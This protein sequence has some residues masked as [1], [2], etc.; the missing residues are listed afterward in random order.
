MTVAR[1]SSASRLDVSLDRL[2]RRRVLQAAGLAVALASM[3]GRP[4]S[5]EASQPR[6]ELAAALAALPA[7]AGRLAGLPHRG[8]SNG[9]SSGSDSFAYTRI[10]RDV[11]NDFHARPSPPT[12]AAMA[13]VDLSAGKT[14]AAVRLLEM[15]VAGSPSGA[16]RAGY[17][18]D[19]AVAHLA[20]AAALGE[21]HEIV[22]ALDLASE[23]LDADPALHAA[24]FNRAL[25]LE[26]LQLVAQARRVWHSCARGEPDAEWQAEIDR[27]LSALTS[28]QPVGETTTAE[29][30]EQV[31]PRWGE[32]FLAGRELEAS[33]AA[34]Q[35][36]RIGE[37]LAHGGDLMVADVFARIARDGADPEGRTRL[38]DLAEGSRHYR[39]AR[40][41]FSAYRNDLYQFADFLRAEAERD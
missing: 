30:L 17:L 38:A 25:A 8:I 6:Y 29:A 12:R 11:E 4:I 1:R 40:Q 19:L 37:A 23:A 5:R 7:S 15:A 31:L 2:L 13:L 26:Q 32:A 22:L 9:P 41:H 14:D 18:N 36:R 3:P 33:A 20:R 24:C 28:R 16:A 39:Q 10:A 34:A 21:P 35:G 27:H